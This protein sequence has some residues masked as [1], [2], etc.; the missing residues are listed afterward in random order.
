MFAEIVIA[1]CHDKKFKQS[2]VAASYAR[3]IAE[4]PTAVAII[5]ANDAIRGRWSNS[6]LRR[7]KEM[8]WKMVTVVEEKPA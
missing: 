3:L 4:K 6:G 7:I 5:A 1:Q 2:D 8:A